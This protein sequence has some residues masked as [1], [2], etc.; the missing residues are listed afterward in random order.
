MI[1]GI[2]DVAVVVSST[3]KAVRWYREKLGFKMV[4]NMG[5]WVTM[6]PKSA[7]KGMGLIHLCEGDRLEPGNTGI[8]FIADNLDKTYKDLSK[9]GVIFTKKPI[10]EGWG[11]YAMFRDLDNNQFWLFQD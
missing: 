1:K 2:Y 9:N 6:A 5:H 8:G 4:E 10:D 7:K 11:K 3:K